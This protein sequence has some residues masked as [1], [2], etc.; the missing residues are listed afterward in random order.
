[1]GQD[2]WRGCAPGL[3]HDLLRVLE[4]PELAEERG[5]RGVGDRERGEWGDGEN[6]YVSPAVLAAITQFRAA[7]DEVIYA[8]GETRF[9][10]NK[11]T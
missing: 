1:M 4:R 10:C 2:R 9:S 5:H 6:C 11:K 7:G 8:G 3:S